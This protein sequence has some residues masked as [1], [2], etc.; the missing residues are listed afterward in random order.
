[1][2]INITMLYNVASLTSMQNPQLKGKCTVLLQLT[3]GIIIKMKF[4]QAVYQYSTIFIGE[5]SESRLG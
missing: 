5:E 3:K 4:L 1:M 2:E